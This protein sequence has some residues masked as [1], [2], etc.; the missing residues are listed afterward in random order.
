MVN[1]LRTLAGMVCLA[2]GLAMLAFGDHAAAW[3]PDPSAAGVVLCLAAG[4][5]L[6]P[7]VHAALRS[8]RQIRGEDFAVRPPRP[9]R[10]DRDRTIHD[11]FGGPATK[12]QAEI[13]HFPLPQAR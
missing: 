2:A 7:A 11:G 8:R 1:R 10:P 4:F 12:Q 5:L 9:P 6:A 3:A 13:P